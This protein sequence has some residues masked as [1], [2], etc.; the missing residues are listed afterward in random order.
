M[1]AR[2]VPRAILTG[3]VL[4]WPASVS[5]FSR[6]AV[7]GSVIEMKQPW[8]D[9]HF[10]V[11]WD[12]LPEPARWKGEWRDFRRLPRNDA[13]RYLILWHHKAEDGGTANI[14][15]PAGLH[16]LELS[17]SNAR[18]VGPLPAG[19]LRLELHY[20]TKLDSARSLAA[21]CPELR[22][23]H[24]NRC[25][26]FQ[27]LASILELRTLEVL[28]LNFCADLPDLKF[29][30]TFDRLRDFRF[31]GTN[32]INGD[33]SPLLAHP[34]LE[35]VGMLDKR[36]YSHRAVEIQAAIASRT[37]APLPRRTRSGT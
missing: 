32:V 34:R 25:K 2:P 31:V 17:W 1:L 8:E 22:H 9:E 37:R 11:R 28:C 13:L 12:D 26:K 30:A 20:C 15:G 29:L 36:H 33:L 14:D 16:Y 3:T 23:L 4:G 27:D 18:H 19:V 5:L 10:S 24:L 21:C 35:Y 7:E 6:S